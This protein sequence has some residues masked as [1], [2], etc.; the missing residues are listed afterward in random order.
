MRNLTIKL[1]NSPTFTTWASLSTQSISLIVVLPLILTRLSQ[2]EIALYYLF[3]IVIGLQNL[4]TVGFQPTFTRLIGYAIAGRDINSMAD[5]RVEVASAA[6]S[7]NATVAVNVESL[8]AVCSTM[9]VINSWLAVAAL[10]VLAVGGSFLMVRPIGLTVDTLAGWSAWAIIALAFCLRIWTSGYK[11]YLMGANFV[12]LANRWQALFNLSSIFSL[13]LALSLY[14]NLLLLV[15]VN[16]LWS[17]F[18]ILWSWQLCRYVTDGK[19]AHWSASG[20]NADALRMAWPRAWRSGLGFVGSK[21]TQQSLG[22]VYAQYGGSAVVASYLLGMKLISVVEQ[23]AM[24]PF[25]SKIPVL[26]RLRSAGNTVQLNALAQRGMAMGHWVYVLAFA[27]LAVLGEAIMELIGAN[28]PFPR[29]ALWYV[30]GLAFFLQ[31]FG[32][33]HIQLYSTTNHIIWHWA[34]GIQGLVIVGTAAVL[35]PLYGDLGFA[36]AILLGNL[37]YAGFTAF[38]SY[39][40]L[41]SSALMFELRTSVA[42]VCLLLALSCLEWHFSLSQ[43]VAQLVSHFTQHHL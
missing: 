43:L 42:P 29:P 14:P 35:G 37:I 34:N 25:Y 28:A 23:F 8:S 7:S 12:A 1:W 18:H 39:R 15:A 30:L 20:L 21:A 40:I 24:A 31:R 9:R 10:I 16:Q 32:G 5:L 33:N 17:I 6:G 4:F 26:N 41:T 19:F 22:I 38:F 11:A 3:A 36:A 13:F 2:E 27:G